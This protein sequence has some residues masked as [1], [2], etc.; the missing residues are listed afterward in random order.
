MPPLVVVQGS[1][2]LIYFL[3]RLEE[4]FLELPCPLQLRLE[5]AAVEAHLVQLLLELDLHL[6]LLG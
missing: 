2:Q 5:V 1:L 3:L 6:L 4:G